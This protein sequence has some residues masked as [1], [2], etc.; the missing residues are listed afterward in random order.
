MRWW[1]KEIPKESRRC[2][3]QVGYLVP[4]H[5]TGHHLQREEGQCGTPG[6]GEESLLSSCGGHPRGSLSGAQHSSTW[7]LLSCAWPWMWKEEEQPAGGFMYQ[8][9]LVKIHSSPK[10]SSL[11][12]AHSQLSG[13]QAPHTAAVLGG[14][15]CACVCVCVCLGAHACEQET[16]EP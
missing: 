3:S 7:G 1:E 16:A 8:V 12:G 14:S 13:G 10:P 2:L 4:G 9:V 15:M 5:G 11:K 6:A